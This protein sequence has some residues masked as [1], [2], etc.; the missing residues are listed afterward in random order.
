M[1]TLEEQ[2]DE[3]LGMA[4]NAGS[5]HTQSLAAEHAVE[6]SLDRPRA[7]RAARDA[8]KA[9]EQA[10]K[11]LSGARARFLARH[12]KATPANVTPASITDDQIRVEMVRANDRGDFEFAEVCFAALERDHLPSNPPGR[13]QD[14]LQKICD[15]INGLPGAAP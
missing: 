15:H 7:R 4:S 5:L 2:L 11:R 1:T 8:H 9:W 6:R 10:E 13:T 14:R 12:A 3:L